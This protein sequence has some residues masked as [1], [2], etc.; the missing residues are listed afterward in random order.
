[1]V[2]HCERKQYDINN[3][4][5]LLNMQLKYKYIFMMITIWT[6]SSKSCQSGCKDSI[7]EIT[8]NEEKAYFTT[9]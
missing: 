2:K 9:S 5:V 7:S 1:M 4:C 8:T 3:Q 6:K